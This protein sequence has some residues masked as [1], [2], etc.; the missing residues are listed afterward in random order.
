MKLREFII[1]SAFVSTKQIVKDS[2]FEGVNDYLS[3]IVAKVNN[4]KPEDLFKPGP[5]AIDLDHLAMIIT[6]LKIIADSGYRTGISKQDIGINPNDAKELF[7][8][9]NNI[10]KNGKD[11][12]GVVNVFK[13]LC[14]LSPVGFKKQREELDIIKTGDDAARKAAAQSIQK[15]TIQIGQIFNKVK[16]SAST[17]GGVDIQSLGSI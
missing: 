5:D 9:L 12:A 15:L 11:S 6:G 1:E 2:L 10:D 8:L 7:N 14:K 16:T 4:K 13:A 17:T 3:L